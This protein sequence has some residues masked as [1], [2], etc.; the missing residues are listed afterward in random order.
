MKPE[1]LSSPELL[2]ALAVTAKVM[3]TQL[4]D[5]AARMFASDLAIYPLDQVLV[6][7][8][9]C[10]RE[11][12]GRLV[13]ADVISRIDD[14]RPGAEEAW[15]MLPKR[16]EDSVIWC[17]EMAVAFGVCNPLLQD[18]DLVGARMAFKEIY[19]KAIQDARANGIPPKWTPSYGFEKSGRARAIR[20]AADRNR[21][22]RD[23]AMGMLEQLGPEYEEQHRAA[24]TGPQPVSAFLEEFR[25]RKP[26]PPSGFRDVN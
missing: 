14:G 20:E 5:D 13:P 25:P 7:L 1:S 4:D 6:A 17:E 18:G 3:G 22:S 8:T 16:E 10:R 12:K 26:E 15:A 23:H 21:I 9:R 2:K 11:V 19:S 24:L